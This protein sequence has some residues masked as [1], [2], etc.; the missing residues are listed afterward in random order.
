MALLS[1]NLKTNNEELRFKRDESELST[2]TSRLSV[3]CQLYS[4]FSNLQP[5]Q[6]PSMLCE[7]LSCST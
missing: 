7:A 3:R 6:N 1:L 4:S 2:L 5:N